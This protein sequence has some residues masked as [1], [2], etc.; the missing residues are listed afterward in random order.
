MKYLNRKYR[1]VY[2]YS[3]IDNAISSLEGGYLYFS[4][5]QNWPDPT[6]RA[7]Y[8]AK[9]KSKDGTLIECPTVYALCITKSQASD[10]AWTVYQHLTKEEK[11]RA[12]ANGKEIPRGSVKLSIKF[13]SLLK[14]IEL[15]VNEQRERGIEYDFYCGDVSYYDWKKIKT[16]QKPDSEMQ[17]LVLDPNAS[18]TENYLRILLLK[19]DAYAYENEIRLFLVK[20]KS[21]N[22]EP[23]LMVNIQ[24]KECLNKDI[25]YGGECENNDITKLRQTCAGLGTE[26]EIKPSTLGKPRKSMEINMDTKYQRLVN[27]NQS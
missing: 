5:P 20:R 25:Y 24:W 13:D 1:S 19:R 18:F 17:K 10:A 8:N 4:K 27:N 12:K 9:Y 6:E 16:I 2:K 22:E 21:D 7:L 11:N 26:F 3:R 15:W 14:Q 23:S